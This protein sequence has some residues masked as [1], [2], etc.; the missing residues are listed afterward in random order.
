MHDPHA[1]L[2]EA[3]D[4]A[5]R[6]QSLRLG[7]RRAHADDRNPSEPPRCRESAFV[8]TADGKGRR[9]TTPYPPLPP[10]EPRPPDPEPTPQPGPPEPIPPGPAPERPV[11]PA[12]APEPGPMPP[13]PGPGPEPMPGPTPDL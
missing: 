11:P 8:S 3:L 1:T 12:P 7:D 5:V 9:M 4:E 2:A 6:P 13:Q 10:D